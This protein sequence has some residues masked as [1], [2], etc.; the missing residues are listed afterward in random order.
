MTSSSRP[1]GDCMLVLVVVKDDVV[2][3]DMPY[4][5]ISG[6]AVTSGILLRTVEVD[7]DVISVRDFEPESLPRI[8]YLPVVDVTRLV[9][10]IRRQGVDQLNSRRGGR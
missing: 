5:R 7:A 3:P 8:V 1:A 6:G 2:N 4:Q 10:P 9:D